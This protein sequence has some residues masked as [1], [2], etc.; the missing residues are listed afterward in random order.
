M[1]A[2]SSMDPLAQSHFEM[3]F[4]LRFRKSR[5]DSFQEF[6]GRIMNMK[7]PGDFVQT[8]PWGVLGDE[9]CDGYLRSQRRFYQCYAPNEFKKTRTLRKLCADFDGALPYAKQFF[10]TWV[11]AHN[12]EDGRLPTWLLLKIEELRQAHA[13][14]AIE[15]LGF[16]E[17]RIIAFSL[18]DLDL[19]ALLGPAVTQRAMMSL[20]LKELRPILAHLEQQA[21]AAEDQ[22]NPVPPDKLAYNALSPNI[23]ALLKAGM[24]KA[25]LVEKYFSRTVNKELGMRVA[26][27]FRAEYQRLR[28]EFLD[29]S[30]IFDALWNFAIGPYRGTAGSQVASLAVL[31]YLFEACDIFETPPESIQ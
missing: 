24:T 31:A 23:E 30:E 10:D 14:L 29:G 18:S 20:G 5:G 25:S 26:S 21:P 12:C 2:C 8:R 7:Y 1:G 15:P 28:E 4:E 6:F 9:K 13:P 16:V 19:V 3:A 22:V 17:L 11:F 27:A